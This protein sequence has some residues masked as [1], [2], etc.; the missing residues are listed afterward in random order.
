T[1][2]LETPVIYFHLPDDAARPLAV[3]VKVAWRG[4]WLT[5][6]YP[7]AQAEAPGA[8]GA[9]DDKATGRLTWR[10][11]TVGGDGSG[12]TTTAHV[13]TAPRAV[14]ATPVRAPNGEREKYLFYRGVGHLNAPL[15]VA[16]VNSQLQLLSQL[17]SGVARPLRIQKLWL[18]QF[19][20]SGACA[21][22]SLDPAT[23][24]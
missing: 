12:Q 5:Q 16:R 24:S 11:L 9:L 23:L 2:R 7:D 18:A 14:K 20:S 10:N 3:D 22:R 17:E 19:R 1:M 6:F 21:F 15:R 8:F 4:G 13:W